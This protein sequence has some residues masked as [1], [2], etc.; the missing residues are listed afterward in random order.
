MEKGELDKISRDPRFAGKLRKTSKKDKKALQSLFSGVEEETAFKDKRG[1]PWPKKPVR[2]AK[3]LL[4]KEASSE[5]ESSTASELSD[6]GENDSSSEDVTER[7]ADIQDADWFALVQGAKETETLSRRLALLHF[8]WDNASVE[9]IF[10]AL[11]SFLPPGATLEKVTIYPSEFGMKRMKEEEEHG[12][13]ELWESSST[14]SAE[15]A[16]EE[17][18]G[19]KNNQ[20]VNQSMKPQGKKHGK[21]KVSGLRNEG[22]EE[23]MD[24]DEEPL[25]GD[26]D[27]DERKAWRRTSVSQRRRLRRYQV[28]RLKYFYAIAEFDSVETAAAVYEACDGVEYGSTGIRFDLRFV[29]DSETFS[30][31]TEWAH[32][33]TE[34]CE[35]NKT[36]FVP[37][38]FE[39]PAVHSTRITLTWDKTPAARTEWLR[40]QFEASNDPKTT[41]T[42]RK[43]ELGEY[44]ALSSSGQSTAA[45]SDVDEPGPAP[46]VPRIH[47]HR[48]PRVPPD[49][50]RTALLAAIDSED[51]DGNR[52]HKK[53]K[54]MRE[55]GVD[56]A[57]RKKRRK[58]LQRKKLLLKRK[59]RE[60]NL[61][62][63]KDLWVATEDGEED[64][65]FDDF[66]LNPAFGVSQMHRN[67]K[68]AL[69][70][71]NFMRRRR[72]PKVAG[73]VQS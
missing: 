34:C 32:L 25:P 39:T 3:Q 70:F 38:A 11:E 37:R 53:R 63:L 7:L 52:Q 45:P 12:P 28:N 48:P 31:P 8:D 65:R 6:E 59:K 15:S 49:Q 1:R 16:D 57:E 36:K 62:K 26:M 21:K 29:D 60:S 20:P 9:A 56:P 44:L 68:D 23:E 30:V 69:E 43:D 40:E 61:E 17:E 42:Q 66:L 27:A 13:R 19:E 22:Q 51:S 2:Y 58:S 14:G 18:N 67:Y 47:K 50:L 35:V 41:F 64:D 24:K 5:E 10:L 33:V 54:G 46:T 73:P 55:D 72:A 71:L 4:A